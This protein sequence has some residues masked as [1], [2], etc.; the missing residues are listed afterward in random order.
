MKLFSESVRR[1]L[2]AKI[3][4]AQADRPRADSEKIG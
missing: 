3:L 4:L 1:S 2:E